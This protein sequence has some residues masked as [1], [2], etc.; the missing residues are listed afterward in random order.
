MSSEGD[1]AS[2]FSAEGVQEKEN[3]R[4]KQ[5]SGIDP[6]P[7]LS[8]FFWHR[9]SL[10]VD[11]S[12]PGFGLNNQKGMLFFGFDGQPITYEGDGCKGIIRTR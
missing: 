1:E 7:L 10:P 8:I 6:A 2:G 5:W 12:L 11:L 3:E 4:R 9:R